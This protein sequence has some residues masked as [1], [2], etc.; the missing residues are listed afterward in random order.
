[1]AL[2]VGFDLDMTLLDTRP[3]VGAAYRALTEATGVYVDVEL[4][5]SR[6]G[7]PLAQELANWFPAGEVAA[8]VATYRS[9]YPRYAISPS[10]PLPGALDAV[11]AVREAGGLVVVITSKHRPLAELH[12]N[13]AGIVAD[14]LVGDVYAEGKAGALRDF[15]AS[16]YDGD[17]V[18]DMRAALAAGPDVAAIGVATG[19]CDAAALTDAGAWLVLADLT[20]FAA[21]SSTWRHSHRPAGPG[22]PV[23]PGAEDD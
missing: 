12:L 20:G 6:L 21:S 19:P 17:H 3:G 2:A 18:A 11:A 9:L 16:A 15:G 5:T 4:V 14:A 1:V 13:H 10:A 7:P 22:I 23:G 8:A